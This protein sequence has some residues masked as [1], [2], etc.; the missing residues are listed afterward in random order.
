MTTTPLLEA[1]EVVKHFGA[2]EALRGASFEIHAGEVVALMGDNGAGKSTLIKTI[3]GV[4][5]PD[6]GEVLFEGRPIGGWHPKEV[7]ALGIETVYQDLALAPDL[8]TPSNLFLGRERVRS[9][10]LGAMGVLA[11]R[12]MRDEASQVLTDLRV[13]I[14]DVSAPVSNLSGGQ[15]QSVAVARAVTWANKL[16]IMDEPTAALGV[17]QT[18]AVLTLIDLVRQSGRSVI[19]ISHSLPDVIQ[20]ADRIEV[21]RLGRRVAQLKTSETNE[22]QIVGAMTGAWTQ[23]SAA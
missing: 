10:L 16:V 13:K 7:Q 2:V 18:Q 1:R 17:P 4:N 19:L 23:E 9:G 11:K 14:K 12:S 6:S 3:C 22:E 8:D 5:T 20:V 15:Q 21:L